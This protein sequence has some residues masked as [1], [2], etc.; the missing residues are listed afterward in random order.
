MASWMAEDAFYLQCIDCDYSEA[1][2]R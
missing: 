1:V 2:A